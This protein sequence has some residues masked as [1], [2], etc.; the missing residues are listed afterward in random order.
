MEGV[1]AL[2]LIFGVPLAIYVAL[3]KLFKRTVVFDHQQALR[4]RSGRLT[5]I[6]SAGAYLYLPWFTTL[7]VFDTRQKV[8]SLQG[9]EVLTKDAVAVKVSLAIAYK[10]A[11]VRKV[12][13]SVE[14]AEQAL[15]VEAQQT[16][17]A[18]ISE[19]SAE[20]LLEQRSDMS[21][22]ILERATPGTEA[23]GVTLIECAIRDIMFPG[24]LK[25]MFSQVVAA[26]KEGEAALER[27][28]GESAA[29]R[30][31]ANAAQLLKD[32]PELMQLRLMQSLHESSGHTVIIDFS[33]RQSL[34]TPAHET[35]SS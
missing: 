18:I 3:R 12:H 35:E 8:T 13:E 31:L 22:K 23:I 27:A 26:R 14:N 15:Y 20:E 1:F 17:R 4:F 2:L 19:V 25:E 28:R 29:L 33:G 16:L 6:V 11:D 7:E 30:N 9:Q 21:A 24:R 32:N 5:G 10:Y 34:I